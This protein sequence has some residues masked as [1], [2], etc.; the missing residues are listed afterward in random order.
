VLAEIAN[1]IDDKTLKNF[2]ADGQLNLRMPG[3]AKTLTSE[4][5]DDVVARIRTL[6]RK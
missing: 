5:H 3:F 1:T 6:K 2:I 4:Q